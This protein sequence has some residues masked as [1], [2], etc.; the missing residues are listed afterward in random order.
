MYNSALPEFRIQV[1]VGG[2]QYGGRVSH[3]E[4]I[5]PNGQFCPSILSIKLFERLLSSMLEME[6][7]LHKSGKRD[8]DLSREAKVIHGR[9]Y[10]MMQLWRK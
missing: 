3:G 6:L 8:E 4:A 2:V 5:G 9:L 1:I 7:S 10:N